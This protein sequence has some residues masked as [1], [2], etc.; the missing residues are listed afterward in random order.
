MNAPT[1][2]GS[3][4]SIALADGRSGPPP[5]PYGFG[6][7]SATTA[8]CPAVAGRDWAIGLQRRSVSGHLVR[9]R[10]VHEM[11]DL[12]HAAIARR[13]MQDTPAARLE[14]IAYVP[15]RAD[16]GAAEPVDGLFR[17]ADDEQLSGHV[18]GEQLQDFRLNRIGILE[19]V[20]EDA[21]EFLT[22]MPANVGV[23]ADQIARTHEQI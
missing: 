17:I 4:S 15:I 3:E 12:R 23:V 20:D 13:E 7:G 19:L 6:T 11:L 21:R 18:V 16:V 1:A 2:S 10:G 5:R 22:Q 14:P 9:E 8:G